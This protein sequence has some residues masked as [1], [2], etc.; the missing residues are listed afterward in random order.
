MTN[1]TE[2]SPISKPFP[3]KVPIG[4]I[5]LKGTSFAYEDQ[6]T[7]QPRVGVA[8][9]D[10]I[11]FGNRWTQEPI[12]RRIL[13]SKF[14]A[15]VAN[16]TLKDGSTWDRAV[17]V[18][19]TNWWCFNSDRRNWVKSSEFL[20]WD[21]TEVTIIPSGDPLNEYNLEPRIGAGG[22]VWNYNPESESWAWGAYRSGHATL[23]GLNQQCGPIRF[24]TEKEIKHAKEYGL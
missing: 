16:I 13:P 5:I 18:S 1:S 17:L 19:T 8:A 11:C 9:Y 15:V 24:A 20:K 6:Y 4:A 21:D 2:E 3:H 12:K 14:G 23:K 22:Y 10:R 7:K